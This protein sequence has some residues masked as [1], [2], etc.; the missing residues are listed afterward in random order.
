[1]RHAKAE[2]QST[3]DNDFDRKLNK[4]GI[5]EAK[6]FA[7]KVYNLGVIPQLILTSPVIRAWNTTEILA[8]YFNLKQKVLVKNYLYNR[9][10]TFQ[11]IVS[12]IAAFHSKANVALVVGHNPTIS[13]LLEQINADTNGLL[14]TSSAVV[15]D[16]DV[17]SW[18][19]VVAAKS[20]RRCFI[21]KSELK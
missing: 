17:D 4:K 7:E 1:M 21:F 8:D 20:K 15:F 18:S 3:T 19:E 12:D 16:F 9:L 6:N 14:S 5:A 11:E 2:T 10:Y 13:Y